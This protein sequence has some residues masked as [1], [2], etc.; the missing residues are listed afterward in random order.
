MQ[1]DSPASS[2]SGLSPRMEQPAVAVLLVDLRQAWPMLLVRA[3]LAVALGLVALIWPGITLVILAWAFGIY[4]AIDGITQIID[5]IRRRTQPRW[6][7]SLLLGL[8][9]LV[10]GAVA[11]VW[12][13]MTAIVLAIL[14]GA[15]AVVTGVGEVFAAVRQLRSERRGGLLL[16][17]GVLS[18]VAGVLILVWPVPGAIVLALLIGWFSMLYGIVLAVLAM[19]LRSAAQSPPGLVSPSA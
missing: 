10:A 1:P 12:P 17:A 9:G 14:V 16:L 18:V 11:L 15:W 4:A 5:G 13:G 19:Q 7:L 8:L 2:E 3:V 6:W